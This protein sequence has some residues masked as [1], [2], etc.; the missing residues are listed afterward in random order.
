M[1]QKKL[2]MLGYHGV[3]KTSLVKR[4]LT[5]TWDDKYHS[6]VG[7]KVD[8]K[9]MDVNGKQ[10]TAMLWDIH[11]EDELQT[12][13]M[14]YM[15]GA[16]GYIIVVDGT[17]RKTLDAAIRLQSRAEEACGTVPF[18]V[19]FNK[20]DLSE[21]WEIAQSDLDDLASR[22][23]PVYRASAKTGES[24]EAFFTDLVSSLVA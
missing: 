9:V 1:I 21:E 24:V 17:R 4:Y 15:R 18:V 7:V 13:Q 20:V 8:K 12:V 10:V 6:T 23:W 22:G 19:V 3:G 16:S 11:G 14:T 5:A 2:C